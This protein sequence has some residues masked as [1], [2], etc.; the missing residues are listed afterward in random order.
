MKVKRR[1]AGILL[2]RIDQNNP[3]F[4]LVHPGGPF[5]AN[6][7][8]GSWSIPKGELEADEDPLAAAIREFQEET[9]SLLSG[10]FIELTPI[11]QKA[12]KQVLAWAI[13]GYIDVSTIQSNTFKTEWP[14][15]SGL[16]KTFPEVDKAEWFNE[17]TA[18]EKINP[19][20]VP[21]IEE[22]VSKL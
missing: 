6:K 15:K 13:Q 9:G 17:Q 10:N 4:F 19:A 20:Q 11:I 7:D 5:W 21:F 22:L 12:G 1:S 18:K 2:Y 14:P 3:E 16:W 8:I